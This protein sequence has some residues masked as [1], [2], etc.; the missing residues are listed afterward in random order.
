M[1]PDVE[2]VI[3]DPDRLARVERYRHDDL[4]ESWDQVQ[5]RCH[6]IANVEGEAAQLQK[7]QEIAMR[8]SKKVRGDDGLLRVVVR[9]PADRKD[10]FLSKLTELVEE[11]GAKLD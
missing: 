1:V 10:E 8:Q 6:E 4:A 9:Y 2:A 7:V 3:V 11:F 5:P